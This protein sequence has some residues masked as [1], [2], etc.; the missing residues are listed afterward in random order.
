[1]K[2]MR[3]LEETLE[4]KALKYD[5]PEY[6]LPHYFEKYSRNIID[7]ALINRTGILSPNQTLRQIGKNMLISLGLQ[8]FLKDFIH[9]LVTVLNHKPVE[10]AEELRRVVTEEGNAI[11][12]YDLM[13]YS[14]VTKDL[15]SVLKEKDETV[16]NAEIKTS[17]KA[18]V[19]EEEKKEEKPAAKAKPMSAA[20]MQAAM[21]KKMAAAKKDKKGKPGAKGGKPAPAKAAP[22]KEES[23]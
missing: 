7:Y 19:V 8:G 21:M 5:N 20:E 18:P 11:G 16:V 23:P 9:H 6:S 14:E 13:F 12:H 3:A 1:M 22:K 2:I 10:Q 4:A 17:E 15:A